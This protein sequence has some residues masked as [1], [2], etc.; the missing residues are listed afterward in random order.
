MYRGQSSKVI[1]LALIADNAELSA[2]FAQDLDDIIEILFLMRCHIARANERA[3]AWNGWTDHR[4]C[5]HTRFIK[6]LCKSKCRHII[7]DQKRNNRSLAI[8]CVVSQLIEH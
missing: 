8:Q 2:K 5:K 1:L 6:L 3:A 7:S 4:G